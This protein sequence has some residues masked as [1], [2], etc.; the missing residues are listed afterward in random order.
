MPQ[1]S[2]SRF[3]LLWSYLRRHVFWYSLGVFF[4]ICTNGM[5]VLVPRYIQL[6]IDLLNEDLKENQ[7]LLFQYL[8]VMLFLSCGIVFV[9]ILSRILFFNPGRAIENQIKNDIFAHLMTLQKDYYDQNPTG[10]IISRINNDISGVRMICG[11]GMMQLFNIISSLSLTPWMMWQL[12]PRLTLYC[13]IP[14]IVVFTIV[15]LGLRFMVKNINQHMEKLRNLSSFTVASLSGIDVLKSNNLSPWGRRRFESENREILQRTLNI[16]WARS[17]LMPVLGNLEN[18]LKVL[19]LVVGGSM[20]IENQF[21][22]G[23][24]TAFI[25]YSALLTMP[26]MGLGWVS[27]MFQ[28]GLVGL[29]SL[30]TILAQTPPFQETLPLS[31][32]EKA[33]LF[34]QGMTLKNLRFRY[35][36]DTKAVLSEVSFRILPGQVLGILGRIGSGKSTLVN[37][38]NRYLRVES[39]QIFMGDRD[40][41]SLR[42]EDLRNSVH[43]VTQEPFLFSASVEENI[44]FALPPKQQLSDSALATLLYECA[45]EKEVQRFPQQHQTLVGEKGIMLSGGQKQRLS[46]AR[47]LAAPCDLLILDNVLSAVDYETERFLLKQIFKK[48]HARCMLIVSHRAT[49]LEKANHILVLDEGKIVDQGTHAE[50]VNRPGYYQETWLLQNQTQP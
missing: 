43:T 35:S 42:Y 3:V 23:E 41:N 30:Q 32:R 38:L 16:S 4:I 12:S 24:L 34:D 20:V 17:F 45:L 47:A 11:F 14:I 1:A 8:T 40:I 7:A 49:A 44:V 50:L 6:S 18:I 33:H 22:I 10:S 48:Q 13:A 46:L 9:R 39:G 29:S 21:T 19:I 27:T 5:T 15:R 37:C 31:Q 26:L 28:Q 25:A 2:K 36:E